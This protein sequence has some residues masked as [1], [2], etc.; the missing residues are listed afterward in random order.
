MRHRRIDFIGNPAGQVQTT[1]LDGIRGQLR[2]VE[3]TQ[4]HAHDQNDWKLKC[5]RDIGHGL[6]A[7]DRRKPTA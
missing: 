1:G 7:V 4:A 2:M 5:E 6:R 3:A